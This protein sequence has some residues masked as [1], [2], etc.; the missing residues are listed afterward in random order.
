MKTTKKD[1]I[2]Y[3]IFTSLLVLLVSVPAAVFFNNP[4]SVEAMAHFGFPN[5]FGIE[6]SI[7][8]ILG[9]IV[10]MVPMFPKRLKE[11][12]YV[13]FGIDFISAFIALAYVDGLS[14]AIF[15]I[16]TFLLLTVSY[17]YFHKTTK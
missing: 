4:M 5:Y 3:W 2:I 13:G 12:A 16:I 17:I 6:L 7:A 14:Q 8:K 1:K 11:W 9:G 10:L 15:P